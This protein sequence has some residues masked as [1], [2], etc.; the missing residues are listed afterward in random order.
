MALTIL[1]GPVGSGKSQLIRE[2]KPEIL[3]DVTA[4]W[5]AISGAERDADGLFPERRGDDPALEAARYMKAALV[6]FAARRGLRG[7]VTTSDSSP[8]A[9]ERLREQGATAGVRTVDPG[10][11][12]VRRRLAAPDGQLSPACEQAVGRWYRG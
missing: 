11:A 12:V 1:R 2:E 10:E 3:A 5:A 9:V 8:E 4:L 6:G 7:I